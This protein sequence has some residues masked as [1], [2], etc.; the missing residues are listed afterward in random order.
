[1]GLSQRPW[2][3]TDDGLHNVLKDNAEDIWEL[4]QDPKTHIYLAGLETTL[5]NFDE[6]MQQAA[7]SKARWHWM[8]EEMKEQERWSELIYS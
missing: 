4:V 2:M 1:E 8:T 5:S 3:N 6:I 7:G